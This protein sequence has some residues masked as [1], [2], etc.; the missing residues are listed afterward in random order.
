MKQFV[1]SSS[2]HQYE[3]MA[4]I[5][6][7]NE[8]KRY[9]LDVAREIYFLK[10]RDALYTRDSSGFYPK[11][12]IL[13]RAWDMHQENLPMRVVF[14][15]SL[16]SFWHIQTIMRTGYGFLTGYTP[17]DST[18]FWRLA[19]QVQ[20]FVDDYGNGN[21]AAATKDLGDIDHRVLVP[22]SGILVLYWARVSSALLVGACFL[23]VLISR[24]RRKEVS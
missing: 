6:T 24:C 18:E 14:E 19:S 9:L 23:F 12:G 13:M 8:S 20:N 10:L 15:N 16:E 11:R 17:G 3:E 5:A 22:A 21:F 7:S 4:A 2:A 1:T